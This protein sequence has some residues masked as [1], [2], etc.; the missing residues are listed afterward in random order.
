[1]KKSLALILALVM[2]L[3]LLLSACGPQETQTETNPPQSEAPATG[4]LDKTEK[5]TIGVSIQ[6]E[7]NSWATSSYAH[8]RYVFE[9]YEDQIE[10]LYYAEC[11]YDS[12][13]QIADI[14][15]LLTKDVDALII[16]STSDTALA[17]VIEK[18]VGQGVKTLIY[19]G[20]CGT[21]VY[22]SF[23]TRDQQLTGEAY[24]KYVCDRLEG[25]GNVLVVMGY[26]GSGYSNAV[27]A[28]VESVVEQYPD[29][30]VIGTEYAE[31]T[32]ALSK[33]ILEGYFAK[34]EQIDGIICDGG[35]MGFGVLEAFADA[36]KTIPPMTCDDTMLYLKKAVELEF[37]DYLCCSSAAELSAECVDTLFKILN[38]EDYEKEIHIPPETVTGEEILETL[39]TT[40]PESYW[41]FSKIP[42]DRIAEF[43]K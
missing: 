1:M 21:D 24:A 39:D 19:N 40:L 6:G 17:G 29:I 16:Q 11:G 14:E 27:L 3:A 43:Y 38:G 30:K 9:S 42:E 4:D 33:Q 34:G 35:L 28:G 13:K 8:F 37:T 31:Y 15:D 7:N 22:D 23:V 2:T 5:F 25:K 12:Q 41:Y 10:N 36:G 32:P 20:D 26:P 18:A